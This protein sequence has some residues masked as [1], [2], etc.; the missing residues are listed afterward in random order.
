MQL[1][2]AGAGSRGGEETGDPSSAGS[3]VIP[4]F[5]MTRRD[6]KFF[7]TVNET[8]EVSLTGAV[9]MKMHFQSTRVGR[10]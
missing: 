3:R 1:A 5:S 6:P 9:C 7:G 10:D 2:A 8:N 4:S